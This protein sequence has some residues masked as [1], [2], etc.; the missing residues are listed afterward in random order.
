MKRA[1]SSA[2]NSIVSLIGGM[3]NTARAPFLYTWPASLAG[4]PLLP[5][6]VAP[7]L[8]SAAGRGL[9]RLEA[10]GAEARTSLP[11]LL[12]ARTAARRNKARRGCTM[13]VASLM[14]TTWQACP[15]EGVGTRKRGL[16]L[17]NRVYAACDFGVHAS[18]SLASRHPGGRAGARAWASF[19]HA[20][21]RSHS[22]LDG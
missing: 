17:L 6:V 15:S 22:L 19:Q 16:K 5:F 13:V 4:A 14:K 11:P 20:I 2:V 3:S 9:A 1:A 18:P 12:K 8:P 7:P 10:R 21:L